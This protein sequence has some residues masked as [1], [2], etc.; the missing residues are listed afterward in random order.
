MAEPGQGASVQV[1]LGGR[2]G[3]EC[4]GAAA[5][6]LVV[7]T[8]SPEGLD[9]E[10]VHEELLR[11]PGVRDAALERVACLQCHAPQD[12]GEVL[13]RANSFGGNR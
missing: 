7:V 12:A 11:V 9:L 5:G 4:R 6:R 3:M 13:Y 1:A 2:P 10:P 8:E